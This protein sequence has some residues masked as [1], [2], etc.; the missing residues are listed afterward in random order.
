MAACLVV[1]D[2]AGWGV[3]VASTPFSGTSLPP[4][5]Y[6]PLSFP[7]QSLQPP[8]SC[9]S[10]CIAHPSRPPLLPPG[11]PHRGHGTPGARTDSPVALQEEIETPSLLNSSPA[12]SILLCHY[13]ITGYISLLTVGSYALVKIPLSRG[14][15]VFCSGARTYPSSLSTRTKWVSLH[16]TLE[17]LLSFVSLTNRI[18]GE[19]REAHCRLV[20]HQEQRD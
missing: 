18:Y 20:I 5:L 11:C 19:F 17:T 1:T 12:L 13:P 15:F 2:G 7:L 4:S 14:I 3:G 10:I 16:P 9:P 6:L 8:G